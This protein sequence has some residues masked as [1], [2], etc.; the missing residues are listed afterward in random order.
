MP[1]LALLT[2]AALLGAGLAAP[3][4]AQDQLT[5]VVLRGRS[6]AAGTPGD[7]AG[8]VLTPGMRVVSPA[9][10]WIEIAFS[11]GSSIVLEPGADFTLT[12]YARDD[13]TGRPTIRGRSQRGRLRI[14]ASDGVDVALATPGATLRV[15]R[16]TAVVQAAAEGGRATLVAGRLVVVRHAD[17]REEVIR[18]PGFAL[19]F[20]NG[21]PQRESADDLATAVEP[22][23]PV[24]NAA[25]RGPVLAALPLPGASDGVGGRPA[26]GTGGGTRGAGSGT[27][28]GASGGIGGGASGGIGGGASGGT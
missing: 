28:G 20:G 14:S 5:A 24:S 6:A 27:G 4:L 21:G 2:S 26:G 19:A 18:R 23:A 16:A 22:F 3:V 8:Q 15:S 7:G 17:G 12:G 1:R 10:A 11:D 9:G 25:P 13:A